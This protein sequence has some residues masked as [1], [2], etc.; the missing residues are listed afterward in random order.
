MPGSTLDKNKNETNKSILEQRRP[1][2]RLAGLY[3]AYLQASLYGAQLRQGARIRETSHTNYILTSFKVE[4][5]AVIE[6]E[7]LGP[8]YSPC[9]PGS[10]P[11]LPSMRSL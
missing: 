8:N 1:C 6:I 4:L 3:P 7:E 2:V 9:S 11:C 10:A 5:M